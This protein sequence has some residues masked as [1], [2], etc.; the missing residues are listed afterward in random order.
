MTHDDDNE[1]DVDRPIDLVPYRVISSTHAP[2]MY[3]YP[4]PP[5]GL[6]AEQG[7]QWMDAA[8]F[9]PP[10]ILIAAN[11]GNRSDVDRFAGLGGETTG[12]DAETILLAFNHWSRRV[13]ASHDMNGFSPATADRMRRGLE[14]YRST[15]DQIG[16]AE[17][18]GRAAYK[19]GQPAAPWANAEIQ[20][21]VADMLVG[22]G[23]SEVFKAFTRGYTAAGDEA[24]AAVLAD[25]GA[26]QD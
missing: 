16:R 2:G 26:P 14:R 7:Q 8:G 6:S 25:D 23:A 12:P 21:M 11:H 15:I 4:L 5:G 9:E 19:A 20:G 1:L 3:D 17:L 22:T 18:V 24:A 10:A 13:V